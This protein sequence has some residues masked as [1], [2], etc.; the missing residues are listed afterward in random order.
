MRQIGKLDK[1]KDAHRFADYLVTREIPAHAESDQDGW[2]IWVRDEDQLD[3]AREELENFRRMP[4]DSRYAGVGR[5]AQTIRDEN[6][7]RQEEARRKT[8]EIRRSW[9]SGQGVARRCPV[10]FAMIGISVVVFLLTGGEF[11]Q[12]NKTFRLLHF[13]DPIGSVSGEEREFY[14]PWVDVRRGQVW[15]LITPNFLHGDF[16]HLIFNMMWLHYLG[17]QLE[18]LKGSFRFL[19]FALGACLV[20]VLALILV[21]VDSGGL[22]GGM[23]GV[24]YALFGYVWM[25]WKFFPEE[26]FQLTQF[27]VLL[28]IVW[29]FMCFKMQ[30]VANAAHAFGLGYGIIA[31]YLPVLFQRD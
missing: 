30:G 3:Q 14:D 12:N 31:G 29:F 17:S 15:R 1:E 21:D 6:I 7:R 26:G 23:S 24:V 28:M 4:D 16:L 11:N 2:A 9:K 5:Q 8:I 25:R 10:V 20:S 18:D 19:W 13:N 22:G 27:T